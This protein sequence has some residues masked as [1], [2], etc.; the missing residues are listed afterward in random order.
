MPSDAR[1]PPIIVVGNLTVGGSGKTPVVIWLVQQALAAGFKPGVISRG[2]GG[3]YRN[4]DVALIVGR[5][6]YA[7]WRQC[8]DEPLLISNRTG[9]P[10]AVCSDRMVAAQSLK[11]ECDLLICDDGLQN[12]RLQRTLEVLVIDG[13]RRFGNARL[14]P[15]GPLREA[16]PPDMGARYPLRVCTATDES[17]CAH[18][19]SSGEYRM[20][21]LGGYAVN[22]KTRE[23]RALATFTGMPIYALAGIGNPERFYQS[24]RQ[25]GITPKPVSVGDHGILSNAR[26]QSLTTLSAMPSALLLT[27]KDAIKYPANENA[28]AVPVSAELST[29]LWVRCFAAIKSTA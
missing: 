9:V 11:H 7:D 2:Y 4:R 23:Q 14:L 10:V 5:T 12:I 17:D 1:L 15:A 13:V 6:A 3:N 29:E 16:L 19:E 20:R 27:E 24:L 25:Q 8:G 18:V 21:L 22:T 26:W 28:W